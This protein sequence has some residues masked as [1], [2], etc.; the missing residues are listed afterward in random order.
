MSLWSRRGSRVSV[1]LSG[2]VLAAAAGWVGGQQI[3]SPAQVAAEAEPPERSLVTVPVESMAISSDVVVR[4]TVRY[5]APER[6]SLAGR[7]ATDASPLITKPPEGGAELSEGDVALEMSGRPLF[8]LE[9]DVPM[10]R[11]LR[12]G[13]R[14]DDVAQLQKSLERM[15]FD[16]GETDGRF[17]SATE[18]AVGEWYRAAGYDPPQPSAEEQERVQS[19]EESLASAQDQVREAERALAGAGE[20]PSRSEILAAEAAVAEARLQVAAAEEGTDEHSLAEDQLVIAEAR[21]DEL[22]ETPDT[23]A[24]REQVEAAREEADR[25]RARLDDAREQAGTWVPAG[26]VA[27]VTSLPARIDSVEVGRGDTA[28]GVVM[29]VTG[30]DLAIDSSLSL[31]DIE[32]VAEGDEVVIDLD[33]RELSLT[34]RVAEI[35]DEPGTQGLDGQKHF[36]EVTPD[37]DAAELLDASVRLTIPVESTDG[38]VLAVPVAALSATPDGGT[39]VEVEESGGATRYAAVEPGLTAGGMAEIRPVDGDIQE[40]DRVVVGDD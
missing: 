15:G 23:T 27:F 36:M 19:A 37:E 29:T 3:K 4:G 33:S 40:G 11:D 32:L 1:A 39:R 20:Q 10:Y 5:D 34:G 18:D 14:G 25:A 6:V 22:T 12:P 2:V 9:G 38:D 17:G 8:A 28:S 26:E 13:S 31:A 35:A 24:E 30:S 7:P 21:L 16:P